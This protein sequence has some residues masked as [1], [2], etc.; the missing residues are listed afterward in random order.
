MATPTHIVNAA[1]ISVEIRILASFRLTR[2]RLQVDSW[3]RSPKYNL[4]EA[5]YQILYKSPS[6]S[7]N[8]LIFPIAFP[9]IPLM[10]P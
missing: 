5:I 9:A 7:S 1:I 4:A 2:V 10:E 6:G 3:G 8:S